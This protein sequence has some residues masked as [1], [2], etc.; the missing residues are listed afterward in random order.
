MSGVIE[1]PEPLALDATHRSG[2]GTS[3]QAWRANAKTCH[4]TASTQVFGCLTAVQ[5]RRLASTLA[6]NLDRSIFM[7]VTIS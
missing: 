3:K 5:L 4:L 2:P 7:K 1:P 6:S